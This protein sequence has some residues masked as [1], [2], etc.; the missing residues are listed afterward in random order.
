MSPYV[1]WILKWTE[2]NEN[3]IQDW[4]SVSSLMFLLEN[5]NCFLQFKLLNVFFLCCLSNNLKDRGLFS[6]FAYT[7]KRSGFFF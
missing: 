5:G 7:L 3:F 6:I 1:F 2:Q 4:L